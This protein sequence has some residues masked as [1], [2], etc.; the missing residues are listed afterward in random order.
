MIKMSN[1]SLYSFYLAFINV[2]NII[3]LLI[4]FFQY[5]KQIKAQF[6]A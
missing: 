1:K 6:L 2:Q 3:D 4:K 5:K